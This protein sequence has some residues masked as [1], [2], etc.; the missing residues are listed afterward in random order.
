M[1][2][3]Q[4][5]R[6]AV[7]RQDRR[8]EPRR[9]PPHGLRRVACAA[10]NPQQRPRS[11]VEPRH[12]GA[13]PPHSMPAVRRSQER[14]AEPRRP[15]DPS[16]PPEY[17]RPRRRR[18]ARTPPRRR[19][20]ER[21]PSASSA[22][23]V[24]FVDRREHRRLPIGLVQHAAVLARPAQRR[25]N[26]RR[27][28]QHRRPRRPRLAD[29]ARACS[30]HPARWSSAR[31]PA[32]PSR[33]RTRRRR[34]R[35]PARGGRRRAGSATPAAPPTARGCAPPADRSRSPRLPAAIPQR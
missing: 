27:D 21:R 29:R 14:P 28:H 30:P 12:R 23:C 5:A 7:G 18:D 11:T 25:R 33:A 32:G 31:R 22:T 3:R 1:P 15:A 6:G 4:H 10:A 17:D 19:P 16:R 26:V 8:A 2:G 20:P 9:E 35:P 24:D 13:M 34:R